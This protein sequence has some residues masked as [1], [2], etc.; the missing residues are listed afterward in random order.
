MKPMLRSL[1]LLLGLA[2]TAAAGEPWQ[3]ALAQMPLHTP[4]A[5]FTRT[6]TVSLL[7]DAFQSNRVVKAF[8]FMPGA[9][10]EI[11]FFKRVNVPFSAG[12]TPTLLDALTTLTNHTHI[13]ATFH[14][15]FLLLHTTE[16]WLDGFATV[17][18][19]QTK[20][21]LESRIV[22]GRLCYNDAD[23]D[24]VF[25]ELQGHLAVTLHPGVNVEDTWHFYRHTFSAYELNEW[26]LLETMALA[27]KTVF[28][29]DRLN[30]YFFGDRR[31]GVVPDQQSI[32]VTDP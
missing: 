10:D 24:T 19:P 9:T 26:E 4:P 25:P 20:R 7:L 21:K 11:Y 12:P 5:A 18:R 28:R 16:D 14:A 30:V 32:R 6:N 2:V 27:D 29:L 22:H 23:W 13:Q 15:P 17:T 3:D 31:I 1:A 8:I